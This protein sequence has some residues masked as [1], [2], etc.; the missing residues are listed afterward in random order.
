VLP[1]NLHGTSVTIMIRRACGRLARRWITVAVLFGATVLFLCVPAVP[2]VR[3]QQAP[4]PDNFFLGRRTF[5]DFGPPFEFYEIFSVRSTSGGTLVER[6]QV[7]PPGDVCTQPATVQV[8]TS[9]IGESVADVLGGTNPCTIPEKDLR[10]EL[11]RCKNC[12]VF[13]GA[14]VVMQVQC[15]G[16]SRRVRMDILDRDMFDPHPVTPEH[17]SW[18]LTLLGRLDQA[19]GATIMER[20][21]FTLSQPSVLSRIGPQSGA[22]LEDLEKG[23]FDALF[24][25]GSHAPSELFRQARNPPPVPSVELLS[26]SPF[27]PTVYELPKYPPLSRAAHISGQV[28]FKL[29]VKSDGHASAP[30]SLGGNPILQ[31]F[32]AANVSDWTFPTEA[33]GQDVQVAIEFKM[34]CPSVQR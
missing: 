15:G 2:Q 21:G 30:S 17:T 8:A 22:L 12:L 29:S 9:S 3:K 19:L 13:S 7:T 34:N 31:K 20:P 27:R 4:Q 6:L 26:S 24:D 10:R 28:T 23:K 33:A 11:K 1:S 18:T 16:Q 32:V 5:F 25:R 14:D